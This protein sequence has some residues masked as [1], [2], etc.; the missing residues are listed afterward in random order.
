MAPSADDVEQDLLRLRILNFTV[1]ILL[2]SY[3]DTTKDYKSAS[4][5]SMLDMVRFLL[6]ESENRFE[7]LERQ[8]SLSPLPAE[9]GRPMKAA[10]VAELL[11]VF[12]RLPNDKKAL[13]ISKARELEADTN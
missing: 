2:R 9:T 13:L 12:R 1:Q 3:E 4:L 11:S 7:I 8:L 6:D 5:R 10:E